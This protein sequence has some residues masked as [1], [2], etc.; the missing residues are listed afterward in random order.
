M[1]MLQYSSMDRRFFHKL[2]ASQLERTLC[3]SAGKAGI[4]ATLGGSYGMDP[5]HY[6]DAKLILIWAPTRSLPT[7]ISGRARRRRSGAARKSSHRSLSQPDGGKNAR[8]DIALLPGTDGALALGMMH[9]LIA[10]GLVD[11]DYVAKYTL[12][13][14]S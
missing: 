7:C 11:E 1:G 2:G 6:P 12:D 10:E 9:V 14:R 5:E 3:S 8:S 13:M 4:K